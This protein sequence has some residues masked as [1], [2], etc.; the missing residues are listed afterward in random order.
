M[1]VTAGQETCTALPECDRPVRQRG[2]CLSHY[3]QWHRGKSFTPLRQYTRMQRRTK[4]ERVD[5]H[6]ATGKIQKTSYGCWEWMG[7]RSQ[8]GYG[9]ISLDA[10]LG[11]NAQA[12]RF[13]WEAINDVA[14]PE[15]LD[16]DH[17]CRN[18]CCVNPDHLEPVTPEENTRRMWAAKRGQLPRW[19]TQK[20][21]Y[22]RMIE[23]AGLCI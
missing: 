6:L 13:V 9:L 4:R 22:L 1:S 15:G 12:H 16:L 7:A 2:W 18:R 21:S 5:R 19:R 23:I 14:I 3:H 11:R 20:H 17:L 10:H 8:A